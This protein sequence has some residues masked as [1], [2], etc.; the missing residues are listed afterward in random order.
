MEYH[1]IDPQGND[2]RLSFDTE[3][4]YTIYKEK[5]LVDN[6]S[7]IASIQ[8]IMTRTPDYYRNYPKFAIYNAVWQD[9]AGRWVMLSGRRDREGVFYVN[10]F[11]VVPTPSDGSF[12]TSVVNTGAAKLGSRQVTVTGQF[13]VTNQNPRGSITT[14]GF[15]CCYVYQLKD[16]NG[17]IV[18]LI[19]YHSQPNNA[20]R[21][22]T[23]DRTLNFQG[24]DGKWMKFT[25]WMFSP[26]RGHSYSGNQQIEVQIAQEIA[27][28]KPITATPGTKQPN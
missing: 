2:V 4:L 26:P 21:I 24:M 12:I 3:N 16:I 22:I 10:S 19:I 7:L 18:D 25:G 23:S 27:P 15:V 14:P 17:W 5:W 20:T 8:E 9:L 28:P 13:V 6:H 1:L 11:Q